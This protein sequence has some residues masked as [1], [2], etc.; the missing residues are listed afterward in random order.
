MKTVDK[1][2]NELSNIIHT[3]LKGSLSLARKTDELKAEVTLL[4][5]K[6]GHKNN[7]IKK[8]EDII[9]HYENFIDDIRQ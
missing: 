9:N 2:E 3:L 5:L 7:K 1:V 8:L 4:Q 6:L